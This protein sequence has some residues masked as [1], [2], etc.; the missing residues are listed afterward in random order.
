MIVLASFSYGFLCDRPPPFYCYRSLVCRYRFI[1][2]VNGKRWNGNGRIYEKWTAAK[3]LPND[4]VKAAEN[5]RFTGAF[6]WFLVDLRFSQ[7]PKISKASLNIPK[8]QL[9]FQSILKR[10]QGVFKRSFVSHD[11]PGVAKEIFSFL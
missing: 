8:Q 5:E 9:S 10:F 6:I 3:I 1:D 2:K 11:R 7:R 4:F